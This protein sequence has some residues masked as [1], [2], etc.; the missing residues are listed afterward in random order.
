MKEKIKQQVVKKRTQEVERKVK[1]I[2]GSNLKTRNFRK[3]C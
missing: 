1:R 2:T 3:S